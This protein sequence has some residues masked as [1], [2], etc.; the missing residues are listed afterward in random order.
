MNSRCLKNHILKIKWFS[1]VFQKP[2]HFA[3]VGT[4]QEGNVYSEWLEREWKGVEIIRMDRKG[5]NSEG[6]R[7]VSWY[8]AC[9]GQLLA[10]T[11]LIEVIEVIWWRMTRVLFV[12][13]YKL[14]LGLCKYWWV[15]RHANPSVDLRATL[16]QKNPKPVIQV[17]VLGGCLTLD[18]DLYLADPY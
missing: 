17:Q 6:N 8:F 18:P 1:R 9:C 13:I 4:Q 10:K 16:Q 5:E 2:W 7:M 14:D 15:F 11:V 3:D 12:H